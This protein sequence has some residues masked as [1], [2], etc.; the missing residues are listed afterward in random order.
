M[1]ANTPTY[2]WPYPVGTDRVRDGDDAIGQLATAIENT[3]V[4]KFFAMDMTPFGA[5]YASNAGPGVG[6]TMW[7][8]GIPIAMGGGCSLVQ[9]GGA[10]VYGI[11]VPKK[12]VYEIHA[13][14]AMQV[15]ASAAG[16]AARLFIGDGAGAWASGT[17]QFVSINTDHAVSAR[18]V[19]TLNAGTGVFYGMTCI[20]PQ[21]SGMYGNSDR[22]CL[23]VR[24]LAP[25]A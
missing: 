20:G 22:N 12:G 10:F 25:L 13:Q 5:V 2:G 11:R 21:A 1:T 9:G 24:M 8:T 18:N 4:P 16:C 15:G 6:G 14:A 17:V 19:V 3:V 7:F 23:T